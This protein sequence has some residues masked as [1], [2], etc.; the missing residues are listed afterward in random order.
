MET[1]AAVRDVWATNR[2]TQATLAERLQG[3]TGLL[4]YLSLHDEPKD[5]SQLFRKVIL[6]LTN[7]GKSHPQIWSLLDLLLLVAIGITG[8]VAS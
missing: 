8:Q 7:F 5:L 6:A 2:D 4:L 3:S 1:Y